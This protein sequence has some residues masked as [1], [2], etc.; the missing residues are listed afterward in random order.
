MTVILF[1][2]GE[3]IIGGPIGGPIYRVPSQAIEGGVI[4]DSAHNVKE[5]TGAD[6][7]Y[8]LLRDLRVLIV[9]ANTYY[10]P[11]SEKHPIQPPTLDFVLSMKAMDEEFKPR[12]T[13]YLQRER[14][15]PVEV[16]SVMNL[17][18][19]KVKYQGHTWHKK[20]ISED[21]FNPGYVH[22]LG[23]KNRNSFY[24][25]DIGDRILKVTKN[26]QDLLSCI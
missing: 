25:S 4:I 11:L 7:L 24:G 5:V 1:N 16:Q 20:E 6:K 22:I 10:N 2:R 17:L 12:L 8:V 9:P 14:M 3:G 23:T 19:E 15:T 18:F 21:R 13:E 26:L